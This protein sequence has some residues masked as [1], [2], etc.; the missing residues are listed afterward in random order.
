MRV[1]RINS[2]SSSS[3]SGGRRAFT[4]VEILVVVVILGIA[5]AVVVPQLGTQSDLRAAAAA[6]LIMADLIYAQNRAIATQTKHYVFFD[7]TNQKYR[8]RM[9]STFV[10]IPQPITKESYYEVA[11]GQKGTALSDISLGT[12]NIEGCATIAFD[13]LGVPY[14]YNSSTSATTALS[15]SG[16]S[17]IQ[18]KCGTFTLT[19]SVEPY[20]GEINVN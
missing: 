11:L 13:E 20:T 2:S 18:V 19:I 5:A 10:D 16:G 4:L 9:G 12:V 17:T 1:R 7:T 8:I 3:G 15:T 14:S 6:R